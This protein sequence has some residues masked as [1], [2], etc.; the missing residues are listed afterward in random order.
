LIALLD[1]LKQK[2]LKPLVAQRLPL[3][4]A[5]Q[6]HEVLVKGGVTGITVLV[7]ET[8]KLPQASDSF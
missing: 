6:A 8:V 7:P 5:R 1:L 4:E 2:K 3:S